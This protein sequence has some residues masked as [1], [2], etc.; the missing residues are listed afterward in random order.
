VVVFDGG[1]DIPTAPICNPEVS[2]WCCHRIADGH[3]EICS[4]PSCKQGLMYKD[5]E[6][7]PSFILLPRT[8]AIQ[9][10][11]D[12]RALCN[13]MSNVAK[14]KKKLVRGA[15]KTVFGNHKYCC[16]GSRARR[17]APGIESGHFNLDGAS[18]E[19]WD[20]IVHA[21]KRSEH[22][23]YSFACTDVIR[24]IKEARELSPWESIRYSDDI[25]G[26]ATQIFNGIAFGVNVYLRAHVD[27]DFTYSVIQVHVDDQDY[28]LLDDAVCYFSFPRLG[29]TVP[30]KP[31]DFLVVNALE[32]HCL[33]SRCQSNIDVYCVS[34]Y[35]KTAVVGGN[36]NDRQLSEKEVECLNA[37][38]IK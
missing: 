38:Q 18:K 13:A 2:R 4:P 17:N 5:G 1:V 21:V 34:S 24:H 26:H 7:N 25:E 28:G 12:G 29:V 16:V 14:K 3:L 36:D 32:Y 11:G 10:N 22:A 15:S 20:T 27:L 37:C 30:L 6:R 9:I 8:D 35:L 23:F 31:G 33:S 19:D